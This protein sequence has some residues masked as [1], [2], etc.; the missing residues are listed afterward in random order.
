MPRRTIG[1]ARPHF[2][3]VASRNRKT[4]PIGTPFPVL[5]GLAAAGKVI[6]AWVLDPLAPGGASGKLTLV[7]NAVTGWAASYGTQPADLVVGSGSP[8]WDPTLFG[9]KGGIIFNRPV[10]DTLSNSIGSVAGWPDGNTDCW[11]VAA[12]RNDGTGG[13]TTNLFG[14]G[15]GVAGTTRARFLK[16]V[17]PNT[18]NVQEGALTSL[19]AS[20][21]VITGAL[22]FGAQI[23]AAGNTLIYLNGGSIFL[24]ATPVHTVT[25]SNVKI[26]S[27]SGNAWNGV[28]AAAAILS[29][30][31]TEAEFIALNLEFFNRVT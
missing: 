14:Y 28:I 26:G 5:I 20:A 2:F 11:L 6:S 19:V 15:G 1:R 13:G 18:M 30:A 7:G 23:R 24:A 27:Q 22:A 25:L 9:G 16:L 12:G 3:G 21:S 29:G 4:S 10:G 17:D 31:A 8:T